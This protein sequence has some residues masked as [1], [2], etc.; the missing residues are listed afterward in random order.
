[1][2]YPC[3]P[4]ETLENQISSMERSIE[5]MKIEPL[6]G[7]TPE[8]L[9]EIRAEMIQKLKDAITAHQ[10]ALLTLKSTK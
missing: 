1:M 5:R 2:G 3:T 6:S 9:E 10:T 8:R 4:I 7:N